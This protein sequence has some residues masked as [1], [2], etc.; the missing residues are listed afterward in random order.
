MDERVNAK[1]LAV[2]D[3]ELNIDIIVNALQD[4]YDLRVAMKGSE[5]LRLIH[6]ELPDLILLDINM[7]EMDGFEVCQKIKQI[8]GAE[9]I[10]VIFVSANSH[11]ESKIKAFELGGVDYIV[12]PYNVFEIK[13]RINTQLEIKFS[14]ELLSNENSNLTKMVNLKTQEVLQMRAA[15]IQTLASLAETRDDDTGHHIIRTQQY[16]KVMLDHMKHLSHYKAILTDELVEN[17]ILAT[18]LHDI[19]K[20]GIPDAILL[21][22][23]RLSPEEFEIMKGHTHM[24]MKAMQVA[25]EATDNS[26]F[27]KVAKDITYSHHEKW[28][29]SGYPE[30]LSGDAIPLAA[31]L[32]AIADVYDALI[33]KRVYKEAMGHSEAVKVI[34]KGEGHH[35]DPGLIEVFLQTIDDFNAIAQR[36]KDHHH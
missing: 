7:P 12:K 32:V 31:R 6:E 10:P 23:G 36:Y 4:N 2:D 8:P 26:Y 9:D 15:I 21:K 20:I 34:I 28:D 5:A 24:G 19:G 17:I 30:G 13:S 33:S 27:F 22:P 3:T 16:V 29:G 14:R 25:A 18:P 11:L 35:F 1:I